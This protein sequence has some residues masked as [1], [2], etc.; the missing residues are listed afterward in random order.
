MI[1]KN[2]FWSLTNKYIFAAKF[3]TYCACRNTKTYYFKLKCTKDFTSF[4][5]LKKQCCDHKFI[6]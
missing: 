6:F 5:I 2:Y 1:I 4:K 3:E